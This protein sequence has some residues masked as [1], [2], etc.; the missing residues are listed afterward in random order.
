MT[1]VSLFDTN[2]PSCWQS[3]RKFVINTVNNQT[4][5]D[6]SHPR[7]TIKKLGIILKTMIGLA[8]LAI[9]LEAC[10]SNQPGQLA[11]STSENSEEGKVCTYETGGRIGARMRRVCRQ[12]EAP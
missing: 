11:G 5:H 9:W 3:H 6:V 8:V 7:V 2:Q 12:A 4:R 10:A 1:T